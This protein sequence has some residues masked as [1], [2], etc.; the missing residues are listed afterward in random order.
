M[1]TESDEYEIDTSPEAIAAFCQELR[2]QA[3]LETSV[4]AAPLD[5]LNAYAS[6]RAHFRENDLPLVRHILREELLGLRLCGVEF[7]TATEFNGYGDS[8][9][10]EDASDIPALNTFLSS[11]VDHHVTFDWYNNDGG[12]GDI[13]WDLSADTVTINGYYNTVQQVYEM[14]DE[15]F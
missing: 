7:E 14:N 10:V 13:A 5:V 9:I 12:G 15:E 2:Q 4:D 1:T 11:M 3:S 8:G 6:K